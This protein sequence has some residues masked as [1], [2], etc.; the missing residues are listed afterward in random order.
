[1]YL[2]CLTSKLQK[3]KSF[4]GFGGIAFKTLVNSFVQLRINSLLYLRLLSCYFYGF[5]GQ[6]GLPGG[7]PERE[8]GQVVIQN[9]NSVAEESTGG[10]CCQGSNGSVSCCQ[11]ENSKPEPIKK[12]VGKCAIWF[13]PLDKEEIYIGAAVVGAVAT[14][15]MI[16]FTIF[17][18][19][20]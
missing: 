19:S 3:E 11:N 5:R 15:A 20:G 10:G 4:K 13:Q 16:A 2:N 9:G 7:V 14:I 8:H 17:K 18:R 12:E 6:M 1:M